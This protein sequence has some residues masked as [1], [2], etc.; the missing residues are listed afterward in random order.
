MTKITCTR[1]IEFDA[2]HRVMKHSSKC[3]MLH[4]HRYAIEATFYADELDDLG[5][6]IDFGIIKEILGNWID[7]NWD[8]NT[9]LNCKDKDLGD[10]ITK[11][12]QQKIYYLNCNPTAEEMASYLFNQIC[13]KIFTDHKISCSEIK[14]FETP[15]C[16]AVAK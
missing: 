10:Q 8:H 7:E 14:I 5:M 15:N 1:R 4:G 13:P 12:T 16:Y 11:T 2:A 9:I 6:V 3:R